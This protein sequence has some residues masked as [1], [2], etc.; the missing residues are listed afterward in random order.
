MRPLLILV[1]LFPAW[2]GAAPTGTTT[3]VPQ[4]KKGKT[5]AL[6]AVKKTKAKTATTTDPEKEI[7]DIA[8]QAES[9]GF[10]KDR[11]NLQDAAQKGS[12][13]ANRFKKI[14]RVKHQKVKDS[15]QNVR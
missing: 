5:Q 14:L 1:L 10:G 2:A 9:Q 13:R 4:L 6:S 3:P 11:L 7:D 12:D 15:I 8:R